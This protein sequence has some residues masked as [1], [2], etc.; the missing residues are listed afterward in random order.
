MDCGIVFATFWITCAP[1]ISYL[2]S[3]TG[4]WQLTGKSAT[5]TIWTPQTRFSIE[6]FEMRNTINSLQNT[7]EVSIQYNI[8]SI[9]KAYAHNLKA[10]LY[11]ELPQEFDALLLFLVPLGFVGYFSNSRSPKDVLVSMAFILPPFLA[12]PRFHFLGRYFVGYFP[13]LAIMASAGIGCLT[14]FLAGSLKQ[15][16][17]PLF[18]RG[19]TKKVAQTCIFLFLTVGLTLSLLEPVYSQLIYQDGVD[20]IQQETMAAGRWIREELPSKSIIMS[21]KPETAFYAGTDFALLPWATAKELVAYGRKTGVNIVVL[22]KTLTEQKR[23]ILM[24]LLTGQEEPPSGLRLIFREERFAVFKI[25][26]KEVDGVI[27]IPLESS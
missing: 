22:E 1:Y 3:V 17:F 2:Q 19:K 16:E 11:E 7:S 8:A 9:F 5:E 15:A 25:L 4:T 14:E 23:P 12:I 18:K 26:P 6:D 13:V 10:I 24:P 21:R 20:N 27:G